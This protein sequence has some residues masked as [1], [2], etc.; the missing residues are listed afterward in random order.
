[1]KEC[2]N[3]YFP[4]ENVFENEIIAPPKKYYAN[5][6]VIS[7]LPS[8]ALE[9]VGPY[10]A[11]SN[12]TVRTITLVASKEYEGTL[13]VFTKQLATK[14]KK[15]FRLDLQ[16]EYSWVEKESVHSFGEAILPFNSKYV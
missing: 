7:G 12:N 13:N 6:Q 8:A 14:I 5:D 15:L 1:M 16:Y 10:T 9:K 4:Y 2:V 3:N 11:V